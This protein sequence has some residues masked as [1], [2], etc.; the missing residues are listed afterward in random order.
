[1]GEKRNFAKKIF[2]AKIVLHMSSRYTKRFKNT[3]F[4]PLHSDYTSPW[5]HHLEG[6]GGEKEGGGGEGRGRRERGRRERG[7]GQGV[8]GG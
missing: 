8:G 2:L 7:R 4:W 3:T 5:S 6:R 1:M